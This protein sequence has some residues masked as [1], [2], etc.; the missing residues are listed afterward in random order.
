LLE[1]R[2]EQ[3]VLAAVAVA[4]AEADEEDLK[5]DIAV[6]GLIMSIVT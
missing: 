2:E 4:E 1:E 6:I 3:G 5:L